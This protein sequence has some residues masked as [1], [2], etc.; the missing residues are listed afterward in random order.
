MAVEDQSIK[1]TDVRLAYAAARAGCDAAGGYSPTL[2]PEEE[3]PSASPRPCGSLLPGFL[4]ANTRPGNSSSSATAESTAE[5]PNRLWPG[6][7]SRAA[8]LGRSGVAQSAKAAPSALHK[9][10]AQVEASKEYRVATT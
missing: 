4:V 2:T 8:L 3:S 5:P 1:A 7:D 10:R 9:V 6:V